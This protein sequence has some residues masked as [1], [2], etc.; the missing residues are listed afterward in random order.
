MKL[1]HRTVYDGHHTTMRYSAKHKATSHAKLLKK[2]SEQFRGQGVQGIGIAK[3]M[4]QIGLTHGG[5]Y[6]HFENKNDLVAAALAKM[7]DEISTYMRAAVESAADGKYVSAIVNAYL[8]EDHRDH[9]KRGCP[10]AALSSEIARQ[11]PPVRQGYTRGFNGLVRMMARYLIGANEGG[12]CHRARLL[13]AGM[14]GN[15]MIA[16]AVSDRDLSNMILAQAREFYIC[17]FESAPPKSG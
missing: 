10:V 1:P 3:L 4:G 9:P 12:R 13:L 6:A 8:S 16:R 5:F 7:F 2:A 17:A 11:P 14:A 15:M